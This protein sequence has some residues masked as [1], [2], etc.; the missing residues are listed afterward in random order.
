MLCLPHKNEEAE[1]MEKRKHLSIRMDT[2]LHDK[3]QYIA[4]YEG[5]SMSRQIL[6][7]IT[8]CIRRSCW[9]CSSRPSVSSAAGSST[10]ARRACAP[11]AAPACPGPWPGKRSSGRSSSP[12][13]SRPCG[14]RTTSAPPST[15]ISSRAP[16]ATPR[17]TAAW[18]P[19]ASG[20]TWRGGT[21]SSPG[22][23]SPRSG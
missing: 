18:W 19:A 9:T 13:A 6:Y 21:T 5:R 11:P 1:H 7:L 16:G 20:S 4:E 10:R 3:L 2:E 23:P 22:S 15:A 17:P 12:C 8:A 14:I